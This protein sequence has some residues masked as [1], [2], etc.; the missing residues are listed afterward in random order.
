[1]SDFI[2]IYPPL[3]VPSLIPSPH[4]CW[5]VIFLFLS[6]MLCFHIKCIPL[7]SFILLP[8]PYPPQEFLCYFNAL[9][10]HTHAYT[11]SHKF[12]S[13]STMEFCPLLKKREIITHSGKWME[14]QITTVSGTNQISSSPCFCHSHIA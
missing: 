1:M 5:L 12:K 11:H 7:A 10:M 3:P 8:P 13:K 6:P 4:L 9:Q 2:F 14:L